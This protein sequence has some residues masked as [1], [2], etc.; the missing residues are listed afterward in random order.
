MDML[1]TN[2]LSVIWLKLKGH[3][4]FWLHFVMNPHGGKGSASSSQSWNY[5]DTF[6]EASS[7]EN[8]LEGK[9]SQTQ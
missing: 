5:S 1:S 4:D 3:D 6:S 9:Y 8:I 2:W 7:L